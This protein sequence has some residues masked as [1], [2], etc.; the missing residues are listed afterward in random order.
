[1]DGARA[2]FLPSHCKSIFLSGAARSARFIHF[3]NTIPSPAAVLLANNGPRIYDLCIANFSCSQR[4]LNSMINWFF[5]LQA[6]RVQT[7]F[8]AKVKCGYNV[9]LANCE[10]QK[11]TEEEY[12]RTSCIQFNE[13][14]FNKVQILKFLYF[15]YINVRYVVRSYMPF[16]HSQLISNPHIQVYEETIMDN[17]KKENEILFHIFTNSFL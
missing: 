5:S 8:C 4:H 6:R 11:L 16:S 13:L 12:P 17:F 10:P 14:W 3:H 2:L 7:S 1:M 9:C 15:L